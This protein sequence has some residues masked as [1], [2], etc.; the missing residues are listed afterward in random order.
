[1]VGQG[2]LGRQ[3]A[4]RLT[5]ESVGGTLVVVK[6][7]APGTPE[8]A[9]LRWEATVLDHARHPGVVPLV[10]LTESSGSVELRTELAGATTLASRSPRTT[11]DGTALIAA[12]AD[13]LAALHGR[14][15]VHGR[16]CAEHIVIDPGGHPVLCGFGHAS[17]AG[18]DRPTPV[19]GPSR[20][21]DVAALGHLLAELPAPAPL[22][23]RW[24]SAR[25]V[26]DRLRRG[27][28]SRPAPAVTPAPAPSAAPGSARAP[29]PAPDADPIGEPASLGPSGAAPG[30]APP[31]RPRRSTT[32]A[33]AAA[34][35]TVVGWLALEPSPDGPS[36][37]PSTPAPVEAVTDSSASGP[38]PTGASDPHP[39]APDPSTTPS[40]TPPTA[41]SAPTTASPDRAPGDGT[42]ERQG[43][44]YQLAAG[45]VVLGDW[46][47]DGVATP[48]VHDPTTGW[49]WSYPSWPEGAEAVPAQAVG[50]LTPVETLGHRREPDGC[51]RLV[52]LHPTSG[53]RDLAPGSDP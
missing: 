46:D 52:A 51:D 2:A 32:V 7:A 36:A 27:P 18:G 48:A 16:V 15:I 49:V 45:T 35:A 23:T 40:T 11:A 12:V 31:R 4:R 10:S 8:A 26:A 38:L 28:R 43:Q 25:S 39:S 37:A 47:C 24:A 41:G 29:E 9:R 42:L 6:R 53:T 33:L 17:I 34:A 22:V 3:T 44:R 5:I 13:T 21:D 30:V 19:G 20:H 50:Q 14:G 1:M